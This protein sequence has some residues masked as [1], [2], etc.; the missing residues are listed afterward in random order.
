MIAFLH[1]PD[2]YRKSEKLKSLLASYAQKYSDAP[3][4]HF[5]FSTL[6]ADDLFEFSRGASLFTAKKIAVVRNWEALEAAGRKTLKKVLAACLE[7]KNFLIIVISE[8]QGSGPFAFLMQ[9]P[10][11]GYAFPMP[12]GKQVA[13]YIREEA[14]NCGVA[15]SS[16]ALS[17]LAKRFSGDTWGIATEL[18]KAYAYMPRGASLEVSDLLRIGEYRETPDAYLFIKSVLY[19]KTAQSALPALERVFAGG[20][21]PGGVFNFLAAIR[22]VPPDLLKRLADYDIMVKSGKIDY[23]AALVDLALC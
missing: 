21:E 14:K 15:L 16:D 3:V 19:Q 5:D 12:E 20:G 17:L 10:V 18:R 1:G 2:S 4:R 11:V 8:K 7:D 13:E 9:S 6:T 22:S 23:A